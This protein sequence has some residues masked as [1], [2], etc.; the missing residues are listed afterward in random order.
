MKTIQHADAS[1]T[2]NWSFSKNVIRDNNI[3]KMNSAPP[4]AGINF[5]GTLSVVI[6]APQK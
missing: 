3:L 4:D 5:N 1:N 6:S 2:L